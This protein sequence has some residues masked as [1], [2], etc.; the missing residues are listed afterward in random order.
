[1]LFSEL[2]TR[3][4][5]EKQI[6]KLKRP[7]YLRYREL[8]RS[9]ISPILGNLNAE[10]LT[11]ATLNDFQQRKLTCG[12]LTNGKPLA[13]NTVKN[14]MSIIKNALNYAKEEYFITI[15]DLSKVCAIKFKE[16]P[17]EVFNKTEQKKI[18]NIVINS[19]KNNHFGILLCLYTG[20][21][22]GELLALTWNDVDFATATITVNKTSYYLKDETGAY[23]KQTDL[24]KTDS[25]IR[26]IPVP[27][28]VLA[29]LKQI[30]KTSRSIYVIS[31]K[32]GEQVTNR[33]YQTTYLRILK[34]ANVK[35]RK[36]HVLR[37]TFATRALECGMDIKSLSEIMGH[38]SPIITMNRYAHSL[39]STK[40]KM[41]NALAK[42]LI[43]PNKKR[44]SNNMIGAL[45]I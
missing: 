20:L 34:K 16:P 23:K 25:S 18:E 38:K 43:F 17:I 15:T 4:L 35:Y 33:S 6:Y 32:N 41:I 42:D 44:T 2:L 12:N 28:P 37:H 24:P 14:I 22:L 45:F 11:A 39:M 26:I 29:R 30:K 27:K 19:S 1:M 9:Q 36:F 7:T 40:Q 8:I 21:R 10:D 3:W 5:N 13:C 31:T